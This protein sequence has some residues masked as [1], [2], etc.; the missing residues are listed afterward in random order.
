MVRPTQLRLFKRI[1]LLVSATIY[2]HRNMK[3]G[4]KE[5]TCNTYKLVILILLSEIP[6]VQNYYNDKTVNLFKGSV[7]ECSLAQRD[8][9]C[10][11]SYL[12]VHD[13]KKCIVIHPVTVRITPTH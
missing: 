11:I 3:Q 5:I 7:T 8:E 4:L 1:A 9:I 10:E 12:M 13:N 2:Y 6:Q